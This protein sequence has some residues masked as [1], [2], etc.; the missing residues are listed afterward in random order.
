MSVEQWV[1][2][3]V[4]AAI[5]AAS[6]LVFVWRAASSHR[7]DLNG[8]GERVTMVETKMAALPTGRDLES[9]RLEV[10]AVR[11]SFARVEGKLDFVINHA[12]RGNS[13]NNA[14]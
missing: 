9:V 1:N 6:C 8:L 7:K 11:E 4:Q 2:L 14:A 12:Y 5:V 10:C 3:A 13:S